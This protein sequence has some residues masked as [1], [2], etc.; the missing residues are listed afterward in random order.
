MRSIALP[1]WFSDWIRDFESL[2]DKKILLAPDQPSIIMEFS[3]IVPKF[4]AKTIVPTDCAEMDMHPFEIVPRPFRSVD[5]ACGY[6]V[7]VISASPLLVEIAQAKKKRLRVYLLY[8][9]PFCV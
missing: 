5:A 9:H 4:N 7:R 6:A 2:F 8:R 1:V 3:N